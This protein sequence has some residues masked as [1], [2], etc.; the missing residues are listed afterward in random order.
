MRSLKRIK[1]KEDYA[2]T[3]V[4]SRKSVAATLNINPNEINVVSGNMGKAD[5]GLVPGFHN[6]MSLW[7]RAKT[8]GAHQVV[9]T[10]ASSGGRSLRSQ[11]DGAGEG[12]QS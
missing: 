6:H 2:A 8:A 1:R 9:W 3:A 10:V 7:L 12:M 11:C 4:P 5:D